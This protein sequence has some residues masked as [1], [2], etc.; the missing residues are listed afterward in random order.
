MNMLLSFA[1]YGRDDIGAY[2]AK[3]PC[4]RL[5]ID[6]GAYTAASVGKV[7]ELREYAEFLDTWRGS[8][9]HAVTLDVIGDPAATARNTRW[10]HNQGHRVMPVFTRGGSA[11]DFDAMVRDSGYVCVGGGVG[12]PPA[13]V[14]RRLSA[15]QRRAE[16]LGGGIHALGVG[17]M[18]GLRKIRPYSADASNVS[19]TFIYGSL[20]CYDGRNMRMI[21]H[22]DRKK[23]RAHMPYFK[24]QGIARS[25]TEVVTTGRHPRGE[26]RRTLMRGMVM[27]GVAADEDATRWEVPVPQGTTDTP[28]THMYMAV[29]GSFLAPVTA[30]V[31]TLL[32]DGQWSVPLW[33]RYRERHQHQCRVQDREQV[34]A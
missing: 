18:N 5:M 27:A 13:V 15:L 2:R 25:V 14:V 10:L 1:F 32:H 4:G 8:I 11:A 20:A 6:S 22:T 19:A 26:G 16:E 31:D 3:M 34:S 23:V 24:A 9:D 28:G 17:N 30:S 21:A 29:T 33:E 12:M 7:I